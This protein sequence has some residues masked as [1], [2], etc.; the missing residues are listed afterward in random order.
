VV[1]SRLS[2]KC[3][4]FVNDLFKLVFLNVNPYDICDECFQKK[5]SS[6][7]S[8][9]QSQGLR[10]SN[11]GGSFELKPKARGKDVCTCF[12]REGKLESSVCITG[13]ISRIVEKG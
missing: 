11:D 13:R 10:D 4:C 9:Y 1:T 7:T 3:S 8:W 6:L 12:A 5:K 2:G